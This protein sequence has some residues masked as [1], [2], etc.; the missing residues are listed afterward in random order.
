MLTKSYSSSSFRLRCLSVERCLACEADLSIKRKLRRT[1]CP[2]RAYVCAAYELV[3]SLALR[4]IKGRLLRSYCSA[5]ARPRIGFGVVPLHLRNAAKLPFVICHPPSVIV[6]AFLLCA[7]DHCRHVAFSHLRDLRPA[8][9]GP[10]AV[11]IAL[12][13]PIPIA[14]SSGADPNPVG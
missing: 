5:R 12:V 1:S 10:A 14:R 3:L 8:L 11:T 2:R 7:I 9:T 6:N 4:A 13:F